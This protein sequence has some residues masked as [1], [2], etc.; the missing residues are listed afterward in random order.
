MLK[1]EYWKPIEYKAY[2]YQLG[3][4]AGTNQANNGEVR[5]GLCVV[6]TKDGKSVEDLCFAVYGNRVEEEDVEADVKRKI[7]EIEK[8]I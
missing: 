2:I 1:G 8:G 7:D 6:T 5:T 3:E 4:M